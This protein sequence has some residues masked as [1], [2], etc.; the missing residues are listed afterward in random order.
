[1]IN[2]FMFM[3]FCIHIQISHIFLVMDLINIFGYYIYTFG[4]IFIMFVSSIMF[5][6][7]FID[8][9]RLALM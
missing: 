5:V 6:I 9:H 8:A 4:S 3:L 1:M 7:V 2:V